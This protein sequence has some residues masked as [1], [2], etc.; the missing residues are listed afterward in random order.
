M[1]PI[2]IIV[3]YFRHILLIL[4]LNTIIAIYDALCM[5]YI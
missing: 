4:N 2:L 5:F 1:E 3:E